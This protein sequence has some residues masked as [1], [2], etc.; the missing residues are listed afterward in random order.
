MIVYIVGTH[1]VGKSTFSCKLAPAAEVCFRPPETAGEAY[2]QVPD[3][4]WITVRV[5]EGQ[6]VQPQIRWAATNEFMLHDF[7][8]REAYRRWTD[9]SPEASVVRVSADYMYTVAFEG[10][11]AAQR[12]E[13]MQALNE[14]LESRFDVVVHETFPLSPPREQDRVVA[15]AVPFSEMR[16]RQATRQWDCRFDHGRAHYIEA[17]RMAAQPKHPYCLGAKSYSR[18]WWSNGRWRSVEAVARERLEAL[19]NWYHPQMLAGI[20]SP[21]P[22]IASYEGRWRAL[23][24][25]FDTNLEGAQVLDIGANT[26]FN[27]IRLAELGATVI[28]IEPDTRVVEQ[29]RAVVEMGLYPVEITDR[30]TYHNRPVEIEGIGKLGSFDTVIMSACHYYIN[31]STREPFKYPAVNQISVRGLRTPLWAVLDAVREC[32]GRL[33]MPT[34]RK[35]A[36]REIDPYPDAEPEWIKRALEAIGYHDV[37]IYPGYGDTPIVEAFSGR[38]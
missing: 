25:L 16:K 24:A 10:M 15:L 9:I 33:L 31:R 7:S 1:G 19:G 30:I 12:V 13:T 3:V 38:G 18:L 29:F 21:D 20:Y 34:N 11:T 14:L 8:E 23:S 26:G 27:A 32:G 35:H 2:E 28:A 22:A 17:A 37:T 5:R 6:R 36:D 4:P